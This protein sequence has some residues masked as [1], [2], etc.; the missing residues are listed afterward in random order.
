MAKPI[1]VA[2]FDADTRAGKAA[3]RVLSAAI[4]DVREHAPAALVGEVDAIHDMRVSVKRLREAMRLFRRLL[5][6]KRRER[7]M[8]QV[9][10][11]NDCLGAVRECDVLILDAEELGREVADDG[12]LLA[13]TTCA[14]RAER[15]EAFMH[16]LKVWSRMVSE[17]FFDALEEVAKHTGK[18][19]RSANRAPIGR[20]AWEA[21]RQTKERVDDRLCRA[22]GTD[23][24]RP[25]HRLRIAIKRLKYSMEPFRDVLPLLEQPFTVVSEAQELLGLTHDLDVLRE[26]LAA[27]LAGVEDARLDAAEGVLRLLDAR[28]AERYAQSREVIRIFGEPD[29]TQALMDAID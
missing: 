1:H 18:R 27:N 7:V 17:G 14:W 6:T 20:F 5:P 26:R 29:F 9:E 15:S 12:G 25:L 13:A 23:D 8:P 21:I 16:L 10:L 28:R 4:E 22:L 11:L 3:S 24:P 2:K 19:G